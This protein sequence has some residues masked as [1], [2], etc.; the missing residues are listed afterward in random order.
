MV[1]CAMSAIPAQPGGSSAEAVFSL[2]N[3]GCSFCPGL[4]VTELRKMSGI[5]DVAAD[6]VTNTVRINYDPVQLTADEI[7]EFVR[8]L[9]STTA[10]PQR[11]DT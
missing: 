11:E 8:E 7:R 9:P 10:Q 2:F 3:L 6:V 4:V 5:R 1:V